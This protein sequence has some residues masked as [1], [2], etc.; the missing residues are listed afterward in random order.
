MLY[1]CLLLSVMPTPLLSLACLCCCSL[2]AGCVT[3][4]WVVCQAPCGSP[5]SQVRDDA[6]NGQEYTFHARS[7]G[8][9][10]HET[11]AKGWRSRFIWI[12]HQGSSVAKTLL[13][14]AIIDIRAPGCC[15]L[16]P[17]QPPEEH[18]PCVLLS[19]HVLPPSLCSLALPPRAWACAG[20]SR[21][22]SSPLRPTLWGFC[23]ES[24]Q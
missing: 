16:Y 19:L 14:A 9:L 24:A 17:W 10:S 8:I 13:P 5:W 2:L 1:S 11:M 3:R 12:I 7:Q 22:L 18:T 21:L 4:E 23:L 6:S 15:T 20:S